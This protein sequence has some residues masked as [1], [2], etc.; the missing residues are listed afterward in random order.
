M[1]TYYNN[2]K[3]K[4]RKTGTFFFNIFK[5]LSNQLSNFWDEVNDFFIIDI[6]FLFPPGKPRE[7]LYE[8]MSRDNKAIKIAIIDIVGLGQH[9]KGG[10]TYETVPQILFNHLIYCKDLQPDEEFLKKYYYLNLS[11]LKLFY[12]IILMPVRLYRL[13]KL[14]VLVVPRTID[15]FSYTFSKRYDYRPFSAVPVYIIGKVFQLIFLILRAGI[16]PVASGKY[17]AS[18]G[19][20]WAILSALTSATI[21]LFIGAAPLALAAAGGA[22][23]ASNT[24]LVNV[25]LINGGVGITI[26][27][28]IASTTATMLSTLGSLKSFLTFQ[29]IKS[30]MGITSTTATMLSV[31][32]IFKSFFTSETT[33]SKS[34]MN[35]N[36][37]IL[38]QGNCQ[39]TFGRITPVLDQEDCNQPERPDSQE[40]NISHVRANSDDPDAPVS[41]SHRGNYRM[42]LLANFSKPRAISDD[43]S[44]SDQDFFD[45][46]SGI[47]NDARP[48]N[49]FSTSY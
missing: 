18:R 10:K 24:V 46:N 48:P 19:R 21:W 14:L 44:Q 5:L 2:L 43:S 17:A 22:F 37:S 29:I 12:H 45:C 8:H 39:T 30:N 4:T 26:G 49:S 35:K 7:F 40:C 38:P 23:V 16:D 42:V 11:I 33:K 27:S 47:D 15:I 32:G 41:N 36:P 1:S 13:V 34:V 31:S 25:S 9:F 28:I 6:E 3:H 20:N